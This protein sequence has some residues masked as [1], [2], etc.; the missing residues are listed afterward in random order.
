[1]QLL[2]LGTVGGAVAGGA[3]DLAVGGSSM[4]LGTIIGG[5][6]GAATAVFTANRLVAVKLF[7]V[8]MGRKKLV[9]GPTRNRNFP[10]VVLGRARLHHALVSG[11]SHA[12]RDALALAAQTNEL[13]ASMSGGQRNKIEKAFARLR[14]GRDAAETTERL[15]REIAV[16]FERDEAGAGR[17]E[18]LVE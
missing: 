12:Q 6:V 4:L 1:M 7:N 3:I 13:I 8:P 17:T 14:G 16:L 11:R 10:H 5:G 18:P 2:G 9:A 15:S